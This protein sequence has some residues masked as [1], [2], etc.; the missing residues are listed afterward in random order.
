MNT[1]SIC[2]NPEALVDR[3]RTLLC[4]IAVCL[5]PLFSQEVEDGDEREIQEASHIVETLFQL[6]PN[7][8]L[9]QLNESQSMRPALVV[10]F[11]AW[12][13][14]QLGDYTQ[15]K[16]LLSQ[17]KPE[18]LPLDAMIQ[19]R[20]RELKATAETLMHFKVLETEHF[21]I[22]YQSGKD[23]IISLF[24]PEVLERFYTYYTE[25]FSFHQKE[26][27]IV[28]V[29]PNHELF[30]YA[31]ALTKQQIETT[32]T[33][34]LCV[35]NRLAMITPR[36]V[37]MGYDWANVL[38]HEFIHYILTKQSNNNA[39]LWF[40]EGV[41]KS[42]EKFWEKPN[43][44]TLDRHLQHSLALGFSENR[45]VTMKEMYPSFAA[46]PTPELAQRAYAQVASMVL[47][48]ME[49]QSL[50][51]I[52]ELSL[53]LSQNPDLEELI[54][55]R[56]GI[57]FE[58]YQKNWRTWAEQQNY[59]IMPQYQAQEMKL[60]EEDGQAE[61]LGKSQPEDDRIRKHSRLGDLLLERNR[62]RAALTEYRKSDE[63][64]KKKE[65]DAPMNRQLL[66]RFLKCH[67][68][69]ENDAAILK[70]LHE[71]IPDIEAD[72]TMLQYKAK[73]LWRRGNPEEAL[74]NL[75][76]ATRV[77]PFDPE[78]YR[79][80]DAIATETKDFKL[81]QKVQTIYTIF[82]TVNKGVQHD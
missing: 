68:A 65:A 37:L 52:P 7:L 48:L 60:L 36:R 81:S 58:Q 57:S 73:A 50:Q 29:M 26:K 77:N 38:S 6:K 41:A 49:L 8:V 11:K 66:L 23:E 63:E 5:C 24:L 71:Q 69:L 28:E 42:L 1:Y 82:N 62:Y 13:H 2:H 21:S 46:L 51:V 25:L 53:E 44:K 54:A 56:L 10:F 12:S 80:M 64:R 76:L 55:K 79:I 19:N 39:P 72:S 33:V 78:I 75:N 67:R 22:R 40:Q 74:Y 70:L 20:Y 47:Y 59:R 61:E 43:L 32:G 27:V 15:A 3:L 4:L 31:C 18:E 14:H 34:A 17:I 30:S 35:E 9:K 45:L 16:E